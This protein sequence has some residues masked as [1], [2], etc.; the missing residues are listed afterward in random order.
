MN[1]HPRWTDPARDEAC[2][3]WAHECY[4][5]MTPYA[6]DGVYVNFIP[7]EVGQERAAYRENYDPLVDVKRK[8]DPDNLFHWNQK[9][10]PTA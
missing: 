4:D 10:A 7:E 8:Y 3:A 9:V 1:P 5:A 6:T 2:I